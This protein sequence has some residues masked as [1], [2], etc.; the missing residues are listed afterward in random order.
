MISY[1]IYKYYVNISKLVVKSFI[2][3]FNV[4][5]IIR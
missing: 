5:T 4:T 2:Y 3:L 1:N